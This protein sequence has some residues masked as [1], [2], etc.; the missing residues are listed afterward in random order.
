[1]EPT[2]DGRRKLPID[3]DEDLEAVNPTPEDVVAGAAGLTPDRRDAG[4]PPDRDVPGP[5]TV[6]ENRLDTLA[7]LFPATFDQLPEEERHRRFVELLR[8]RRDRQWKR[9]LGSFF[10]TEEKEAINTA[11]QQ[12]YLS[13][14]ERNPHFARD[15]VSEVD[16]KIAEHLDGK[17]LRNL[18]ATSR[19]MRDRYGSVVLRVDRILQDALGI[20]P[21]DGFGSQRTIAALSPNQRTEYC[22]VLH[23]ARRK[24]EKLVTS[25]LHHPANTAAND[26]F[27]AYLSSRTR[28]RSNS[29]P[30]GRT[31][32]QVDPRLNRVGES[33]I[34]AWIREAGGPTTRGVVTLM[35]DDAW[36]L[37]S[38]SDKRRLLAALTAILAAGDLRA[39]IVGHWFSMAAQSS[40]DEDACDHLLRALR[41]HI[42][43]RCPPEHR[44]QQARLLAVIPPPRV[45]SRERGG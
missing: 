2:Q 10:Q 20:T 7:N 25:W 44:T 9:A 42:K 23:M 29:L 37:F 30:D 28:P 32:A 6:D 14:A 31:R 41:E 38:D 24:H 45:L 34:A 33:T 26:L 27:D 3:S 5:N 4:P 8:M 35:N 16:G 1:M 18:S 22:R 40:A 15:E 19:E 13:R 39:D 12:W 17:S 21:Q 36:H 11:Y 43:R